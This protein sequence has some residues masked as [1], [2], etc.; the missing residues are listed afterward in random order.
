MSFRAAFVRVVFTGVVALLLAASAR[1]PLAEAQA[2]DRQVIDR[3]AAVVGNDIVLKSEVDQLVLQMTQGSNRS[4]STSMWMNA[5]NQLVDQKVL[6]EHARRDTT[7]TVS[8]QQ[9]DQQLGRRIEQLKQR[10]GGEDA[11]EE[12]Y[13]KSLLELREDF[14]E[15]LRDQLLAER[16]RARHMQTIDITPSE[17][18]TWFQRIPQDSLPRIP[19]TVRLA[20][21]VRYPKP[22]PRAK[23]E[24]RQ[25]IT[26][27]RD[28]IVNSGAS[29]ETMAQQF[30]DDPG[31]ASQG[32]RF[33]DMSVND[34]VPEFAAMASR[35][36]ESQV[37]PVFYNSTHN[38]Y[39]ILRVNDRSGTS[40]DLNHILI[41]VDPSRSNDDQALKTLNAIKDTLETYD[42]PF[43]LMARRHSEEEQSAKN[44]G[45]VLDP[46][47]QTRDLVLDALG[48]SWRRTI[49]SIDVGDISD[50]AEVQLLNGE[51][52]YHIVLLQRRQPAH[53]VSVETD[54]ERIQQLALQEKQQREMQTWVRE[55]RDDVYVDIRIQEDDLTAAT[56]F[57]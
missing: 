34:F 51:R 56:R 22:T 7:L 57:R 49:R 31:S 13:G 5:L 44:G 21:I 30:S 23:Q 37:S 48:P 55:L 12:V 39:H 35:T 14:R 36:P 26:A 52:A 11:L 10:A 1:A 9:V 28:S 3:I 40:I 41:R 42:V 8:D 50:P 15:T 24:A 19:E 18:R 4:Y 27:I 54:Y 25:V 6:A 47:S 43:E 29:F 33:T 20:H 46:R 45:R 16:F 32:G 2:Q 53:R 38:G 17:V